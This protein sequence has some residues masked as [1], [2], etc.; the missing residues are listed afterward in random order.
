M[1]KTKTKISTKSKGHGNDDEK[2]GKFSNVEYRNTHRIAVWLK[3]FEKN[4]KINL[5]RIFAWI[6][7]S[8]MTRF[9]LKVDVVVVLVDIIDHCIH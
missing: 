5:Q 6:V 3:S 8:Q 7:V 9:N 4:Q 1:I 2:K